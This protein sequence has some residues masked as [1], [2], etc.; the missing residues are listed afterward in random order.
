VVA[1][2]GSNALKVWDLE[3]G[4]ELY[5]LQG[6][7]RIVRH[8]AITADGRHVV[9][10]SMDRTVKVWDLERGRELRTLVGHVGDVTTVAVSADGRLVVSGSQQDGLKVWDLNTGSAIAG[11]TCEGGPLCCAFSAPNE[12]VA[13]D[14]TGR[15][16][17]LQLVRKQ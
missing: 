15:V 17:R 5:M 8:L 16:Y 2:W 3:S 1:S 12:I 10:A 13:G 11:F 14:M 4:R 6:H 9:S 7:T